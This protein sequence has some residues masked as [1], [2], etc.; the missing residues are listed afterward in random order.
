MVRKNS[1]WNRI[2]Q[3]RYE[4]NWVFQCSP[5]QHIYSVCLLVQTIAFFYRM[6]LS[7]HISFNAPQLRLIFWV[8]N[9]KSHRTFYEC[10]CFGTFFKDLCSKN[11]NTHF[12]CI[13]YFYWI[14]EWRRWDTII[15]YYNLLNCAHVDW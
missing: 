9:N 6:N 12:R 4:W 14:E 15:L 7:C 2:Y 1:D 10:V 5:L 8:G 13:S 11:I 3:Y